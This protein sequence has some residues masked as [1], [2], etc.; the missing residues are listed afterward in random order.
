MLLTIFNKARLL[1]LTLI[2]SGGIALSACSSLNQRPYDV[3]GIYNNSKI[4]VE[5]THY[6]GEYYSEYFKEKTEDSQEY[7]T[8]VDN[9][10]SG[11]NQAYGAWG[12]E[13]SET[14]INHYYPYNNWFGWGYPYDGWGMGY[15]MMGYGMMGWGY[16][17][18][19]GYG[20]GWGGYWG[21]PYSY[22][23]WGYPYYSHRNISRNNSHR[24]LTSR[25]LTGSNVNRTATPNSRTLRS[26]AQNPGRNTLTTDRTFSRANSNA[27]RINAA[28]RNVQTRRATPVDNSRTNRNNQINTRNTNRN[29]NVRTQQTAPNRSYTPAPSTRMNTGSMSRGGGGMRSG[30]G[31]RR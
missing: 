28:N 23:G 20:M 13:T 16:G 24:A 18:G 3:D 29:T 15:G 6:H 22:Y 30:G 26:A 17:F 11:Y 9:Y 12:D 31:G 8:D 27:N 1:R 21:Y 5:D 14:Y 7:F 4:V 25:Q 2:V 19:W 10:T